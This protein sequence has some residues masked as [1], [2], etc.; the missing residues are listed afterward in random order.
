MTD[1]IDRTFQPGYDRH[2]NPD[3]RYLPG[4]P[5]AEADDTAGRVYDALRLTLA[6]AS[7]RAI[8]AETGLTARQQTHALRRH[9]HLRDAML[10][11]EQIR[12]RDGIVDITE[13]GPSGR[14]RL[15]ESQPGAFTAARALLT[16]MDAA[17]E[18]E[19][20]SLTLTVLRAGLIVPY[21]SDAPAPFPRINSTHPAVQV[22]RAEQPEPAAAA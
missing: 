18:A 11:D 4:H 2:G 12:E 10:S 8:I 21:S 14:T 17:V 16:R 15:V 1:L 19:D 9:L 7:I 6:G 3:D 20:G 22:W 13:D 5:W